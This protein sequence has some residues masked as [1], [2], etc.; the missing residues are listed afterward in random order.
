MSLYFL[1]NV[2]GFECL[3]DAISF[4]NCLINTKLEEFVRLFSL[5]SC[6]DNVI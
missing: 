4:N 2:E 5:L 3:D 6:I 1:V